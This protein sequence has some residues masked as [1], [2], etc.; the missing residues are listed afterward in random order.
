MVFHTLRYSSTKMV[1][2]LFMQEISAVIVTVTIV[3][4]FTE[5]PYAMNFQSLDKQ[6]KRLRL[7]L[8]SYV[9]YLKF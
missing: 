6:F 8:I 3:A 7:D 9:D 4:V 1:R 5:T 2:I